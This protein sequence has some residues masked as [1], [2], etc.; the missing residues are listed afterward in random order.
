MNSRALH[1][2]FFKAPKSRIPGSQILHIF[3]S[4]VSDIPIFFQISFANLYSYWQCF[5][6]FGMQILVCF[7]GNLKMNLVICKILYHIFLCFVQ[8]HECKLTQEI[9]ELIDREVD[10][11]MR[12]V[13]H[14]NLEGLRK[15]IATLF[16]HYIK[17]PLFNPEVAKY[18]K[19]FYFFIFLFQN[20]KMWYSKLK[21]IQVLL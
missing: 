1:A 9:L 17:T 5:I 12:G 20:P 11:M 15:R 6:S 4:S 19:V 18:L 16:F 7:G 10:L 14:H 21:Y 8:E 2:H 13:K 3:N